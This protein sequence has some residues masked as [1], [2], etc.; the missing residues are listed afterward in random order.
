MKNILFFRIFIILEIVGFMM[1]CACSSDETTPEYYE[2]SKLVFTDTS[3]ENSNVKVEY[4]QIKGKGHK[5]VNELIKSFAKDFAVN[6]YSDDY[7]NL[8]LEVSYRISYQDSELL[9]IVFYGFGNVSTAAYPNE[10]LFA[11][12]VDLSDSKVLSFSDIFTVNNESLKIVGDN[13]HEQFILKKFGGSTNDNAKVYEDISYI[14]ADRL[15]DIISDD[16]KFYLSEKSI[17]ICIELQH[18]VGDNFEIE[19]EYSEL[20]DFIKL[21]TCLHKLKST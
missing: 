19:V 2:F 21:R 15:R 5:T 12:N 16:T 6:V 14:G 8:D 18:A 11:I 20:R 13:Y 9:S 7:S 1:L 10:L 4:P 17:T 3:H